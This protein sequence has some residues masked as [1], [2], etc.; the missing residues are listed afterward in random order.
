MGYGE[1]IFDSNFSCRGK[2]RP[3]FNALGNDKHKPD[4]ETLD[5]YS[6]NKRWDSILN[7]MAGVKLKDY[8]DNIGEITKK[9]IFNAKLIEQEEDKE[10]LITA[11]GFQFLLMDIS[12]QVWYFIRK[13]L[14][15]VENFSLNFIEC[16]SFLFELNFLTFGKVSN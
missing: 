4:I 10:N 13:Y 3:I 9:V 8:N 16:L 1:I 2:P 12:L 15:L 6:V 11:S 7:Y 14:E 5:N